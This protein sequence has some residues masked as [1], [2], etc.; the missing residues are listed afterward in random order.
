MKT[1]KIIATVS[2]VRFSTSPSAS[3]VRFRLMI[4]SNVAPNAPT[5]AAS[6][7]VAQPA[8]MEPST[9]TI[10]NTGG[11]KPRST[12]A[13]SSAMLPGPRSSGSGG[14]SCGQI[15]VSSMI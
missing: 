6:D 9:S 2:E 7:G 12:M 4:A 10:R 5:A 15:R 14:P 13:P 8:M 1:K 11:M 3:S